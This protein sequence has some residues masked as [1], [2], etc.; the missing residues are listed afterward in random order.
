MNYALPPTFA[1]NV[2]LTIASPFLSCTLPHRGRPPALGVTVSRRVQ[3][4]GQ[5]ALVANSA[6]SSANESRT[7]AGTFVPFLATRKVP[8]QFTVLQLYAPVALAQQGTTGIWDDPIQ[9]KQVRPSLPPASRRQARMDQPKPCRANVR[10]AP[11][12]QIHF[13]A[14]KWQARSGPMF[15]HIRLGHQTIFVAPG[16]P[17]ISH[18]RCNLIVWIVRSNRGHVAP[19]RND[20][21]YHASGVSHILP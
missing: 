8:R 1:P 6:A 2:T 15:R 4:L 18:D 5:H 19:A 12:P 16:V 20:G 9:N 3:P 13:A 21:S 17:Y 14:V 7:V 10:L 11:G